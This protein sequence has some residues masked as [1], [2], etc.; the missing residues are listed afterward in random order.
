M[1]GSLGA[2]LEEESLEA[3]LAKPVFSETN[4][5]EGTIYSFKLSGEFP[6]SLVSFDFGFRDDVLVVG[7]HFAATTAFLKEMGNGGS[8]KKLSQGDF[9]RAVRSIAPETHYRNSFAVMRGV[10]DVWQYSLKTMSRMALASESRV[11]SSEEVSGDW[12]VTPIDMSTMESEME[13]FSFA[14]GAILRT[15][16]LVGNDSVSRDGFETSSSRIVI[17]S[18]PLEEKQR[19]ERILEKFSSGISSMD[20]Q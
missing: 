8:E 11:A 3:L 7:T 18:L 14:M 12:S 16:K 10:W 4:T 2:S 9:Y 5:A 13:D 20:A 6:L 19:A 15:V 1:F 17:E